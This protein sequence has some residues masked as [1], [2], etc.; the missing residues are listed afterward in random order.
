MAD[1]VDE[2]REAHELYAAA[3]IE[4]SEGARMMAVAANEIERLRKALYYADEG[5]NYTHLY[6]ETN[7]NTKEPSQ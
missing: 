1:I 2:L 5:C 3:G 6:D 7:Y 4:G